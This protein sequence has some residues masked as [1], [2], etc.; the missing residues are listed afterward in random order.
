MEHPYKGLEAR[1]F[2]SRSVGDRHFYQIESLGSPKTLLRR[3]DKVATAGSCFA[4][5][6]ARR[7][8]ADGYAFLDAEPAPHPLRAEDQALFGY[9]LF[10]ARYGN[11]YTSRQL[12]QLYDRAYGRFDPEEGA[13]E[14]AGRYYD[15][16][17]PAVEP[18]G[19]GSLR[20]LALSR[21]AHLAAVRRIFRKAD[22][23]VFTLGLTECWR[24][25]T[26]GAVYPM[27]P[28]TQAGAFDPDKY[29]FVNLSY[30]DVVEDLRYLI[31]NAARKRPE[32]R[33]L[34]TVSPVPLA[35]TAAGA[36]VLTATTYSKSVLRA[37][38]GAL[39]DMYANVDYFPSYEIISSPPFR[40]TFFDQ[41][42][43]EVRPEGVD[44]VMRAFKRDFCEVEA[45]VIPTTRPRSLDEEDLV[46]EER[47]LDPTAK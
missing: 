33:F 42:L 44:V 39:A 10:S 32:M 6:I 9:G 24:S 19:F 13:W 12:R 20:E 23:F 47:A 4:Q 22:V 34:F 3:S 31:D 1:A 30:N 14:Q 2:W 15:P 29:E 37:A 21:H 5:H 16:F 41:G 43:R 17:R 27:C 45:D 18:D 38:A 7:L 25:R 11:V 28:G 35:A 46:C 40:G 26:D 36:H 8:R